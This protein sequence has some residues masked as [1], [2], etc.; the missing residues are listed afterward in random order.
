MIEIIMS[1]ILL[2]RKKELFTQQI[3]MR[4][5]TLIYHQNR[6]EEQSGPFSVLHC[7]KKKNLFSLKNIFEEKRYDTHQ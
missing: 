5:C 2:K 3:I 6:A 1:R 4:L 7:A